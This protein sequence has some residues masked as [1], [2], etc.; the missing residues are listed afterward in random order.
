[1]E[2]KIITY[3][4]DGLP[5][6]LDLSTL[7]WVLKPIAWIY[8]LIKGTYEVIINDNT[9][10]SNNMKLI[11]DYLRM[12]NADLI[13]VQEDFNYHNEL[14]NSL[15]QHSS[16]TYTGGF[17]L[18]HIFSKVQW[19]PK[20]RFK[21][22]GLNLFVKKNRIKII[23]EKIIPWNKS[24]GYVSNANDELTKKGFR[25][26]ILFVDDMY[27]IDVYVVH[28]D[29]NFYKENTSYSDIQDDVLTR[30]S[31]LNQLASYILKKTKKSQG[32]SNPAIIIGDTNCYNKYEWD[33][34]NIERRLINSINK[35]PYLHI[36]EITP[37]N[38][39]DCDKIFI[40]NNKKRDYILSENKCYFDKTV[41]YSDHY[42]LITNLS[43]KPL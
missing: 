27:Y 5:E 1:M 25:E 13:S 26:Y 36:R 41:Y 38:H 16:G 23:D 8:K 6:K 18:H 43:I 42:P 21:C 30:Q 40:I 7:P 22:D 39:S 20:P 19:L 24:N 2:L 12:E 4:I 29:A 14:E 10:K 37:E 17:D 3:N 9:N 15:P 35:N 33:A 34:Q 28:M 11:G 32:F 31:Q